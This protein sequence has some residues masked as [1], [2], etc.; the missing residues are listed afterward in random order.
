MAKKLVLVGRDD[1]LSGALLEAFTT[2]GYVCQSLRLEDAGSADS[3]TVAAK[4]HLTVLS[5]DVV[6]ICPSWRGRG[7]FLDSSAGEWQEAL[8]ENVEVVTYVMQAAADVFKASQK[9]GRIIVTSHVAALTPF[10]GLSLLGTTLAAVKALV[11]MLALELAPLKTTVNSVALGPLV[12]GLE[13]PDASTDKLRQDT[14]LQDDMFTA[15]AEVCLF[16]ASEAGGHLTG[17]TL[18][19]E[20]GFLL[21]RASGGSPYAD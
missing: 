9:E 8:H 10:R 16:L 11:K 5:P 12:E 17:Q 14:P 15:A 20:G 13:L 2:H 19:V 4:R 6:V 18:P 7:A 21:T 1:P 3:I